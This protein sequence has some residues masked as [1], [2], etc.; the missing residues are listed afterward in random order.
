MGFR[1]RAATTRKVEV[2]DAVKEE[3]G[4]SLYYDIVQKVTRHNIP[5]SLTMNLDQTPSKFIPGSKAMQA[6]IVSSTVPI[7]GSTEKKA[8][9][10]TFVIVLNGAFLPIQ[11]IC[12][13]KATRY[14]PRVKFPEAFCLSFNEKQWGNEKE[15]LKIIEDIIVPYVTKER[16]K[17]S[18]PNQPALLIMDV[19]K[20][21][22]TN[23]CFEEIRRTQHPT[24]QSPGKHETSVSAIRPNCQW[25]FQAIHEAQICGM[26]RS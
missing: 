23:P 5:P 16:E 26:V 21:Q 14:L 24:Y 22:M 2:P 12:E 15:S 4:L 20:G 10:L 7:A 11:E 25:L 17:L 19:F 1:R 13:G 9:I 6:K 8:I 18:S 3:L